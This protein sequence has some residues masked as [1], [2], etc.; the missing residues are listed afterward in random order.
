[1]KQNSKKVVQSYLRSIRRPQVLK[2]LDPPACL[3]GASS[4]WGPWRRRAAVH[5]AH[6]AASS[7]SLW[8]VCSGT[9][10]ASK[11]QQLGVQWF[12]AR[13]GCQTRSTGHIIFIQRCISSRPDDV[14]TSATTSIP[15]AN[16]TAWSTGCT[17]AVIESAAQRIQVSRLTN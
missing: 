9:R 12:G 1:M 6:S 14:T 2:C 10:P 3:P 11:P 15:A 13:A 5:P 8:T 4:S 17:F 16:I 7:V